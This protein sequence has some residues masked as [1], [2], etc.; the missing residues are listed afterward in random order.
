M[1][2]IPWLISVKCLDFNTKFNDGER[3]IPHEQK[4]R[5]L[6]NTNSRQ[7]SNPWHREINV[8]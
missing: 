3:S 4:V 5:E 2:K 6:T 7:F 1:Y 8:H